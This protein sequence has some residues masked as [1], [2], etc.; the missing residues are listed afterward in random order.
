MLTFKIIGPAMLFQ[1]S[2]KPGER[3]HCAEPGLKP[4]SRPAAAL[5]CQNQETRQ[6]RNI[7][8]FCIFCSA[9]I[10]TGTPCPTMVTCESMGH[11]MLIAVCSKSNWGKRR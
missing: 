9:I 3:T 8:F 1:H 5:P 11:A 6:C 7:E 10:I 2:S 4:Q